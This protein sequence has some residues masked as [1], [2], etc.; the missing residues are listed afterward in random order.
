VFQ[1]QLARYTRALNAALHT[2][3]REIFLITAAICAVGA[4]VCLALGAHRRTSL[5]QTS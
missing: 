3:Y 2:E 4:V 5:V 1:R